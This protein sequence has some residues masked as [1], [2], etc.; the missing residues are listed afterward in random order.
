MSVNPAEPGVRSRTKRNIYTSQPNHNIVRDYNM[1]QGV[2][3]PADLAY[4][5][6]RDVNTRRVAIE[7]SAPYPISFAIVT[8]IS[9][10][11][12]KILYTLDPGEI[13]FLAIN[14]YFE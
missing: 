4:Q 3:N 12:P 10:P 14:Q 6:R 11:I 5:I 7:N 9:G 1:L 13:L 2:T 8:Y